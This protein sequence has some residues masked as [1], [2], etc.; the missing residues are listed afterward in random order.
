MPNLVQAY[1]EEVVD[2]GGLPA[3]RIEVL[4]DLQSKTA[5]GRAI[6]MYMFQ[7]NQAH[8]VKLGKCVQTGPGRWQY[9]GRQ[10]HSVPA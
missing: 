4:R 7:L 9:G 5:N 6:S 2:F 8:D 10:A 1:M 3:R